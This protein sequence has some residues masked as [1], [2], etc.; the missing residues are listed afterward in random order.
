MRKLFYV[1][2]NSYESVRSQL[3]KIVYQ[4]KQS[5]NSI[6]KPAHNSN[7]KANCMKPNK[8]PRKILT[9]YSEIALLK[10]QG[11]FTNSTTVIYL[12]KA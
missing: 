12:K 3:Y 7:P 2:A 8:S 10:I 11:Y 5:R 9:K 1:V 4:K 6:T